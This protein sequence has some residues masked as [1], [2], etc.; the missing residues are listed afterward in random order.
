M[1]TRQQARTRT[2]STRTAVHLLSILA[3][4][5][6]TTIFGHSHSSCMLQM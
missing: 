2:L 1:R 4:K 3:Q 6:S 5:C